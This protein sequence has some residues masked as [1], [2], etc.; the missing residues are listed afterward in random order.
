MIGRIS[1]VFGKLFNLPNPSQTF[2]SD[3]HACCFNENFSV[4][5]P[6]IRRQQNKSLVI[7][8]ADYR[9]VCIYVT[10]LVNVLINVEITVGLVSSA[11]ARLTLFFDEAYFP[12]QRNI[13]IVCNTM[14]L[15]EAI[16]WCRRLIR[17]LLIVVKERGNKNNDKKKLKGI[18]KEK[19][20]KV[21]REKIQVYVLVA[22]GKWV[23][24][25][26]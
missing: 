16:F 6:Y 25:T 21:F 22:R 20:M 13:P 3:F 8:S 12:K 24:D 17:L 2:V 18:K 5:D 19:T 15:A 1:T 10:E 7:Y 11:R 23:C 9:P 4:Y 14:Q 26:F